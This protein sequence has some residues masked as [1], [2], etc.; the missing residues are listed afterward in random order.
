MID[1]VLIDEIAKAMCRRLGMNPDLM[2]YADFYDVCIDQ[3]ML[4]RPPFNPV[5]VDS[6]G[7]RIV[8]MPRDNFP[9]WKLFR[10]DAARALVAREAVNDA[11]LLHPGLGP[12][13]G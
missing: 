9:Q 1:P 2:V 13:G 6:T 12:S 5:Q 10:R 11:L 7:M 4:V 8:Q 3:E